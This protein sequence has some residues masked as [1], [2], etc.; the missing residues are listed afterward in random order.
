[1]WRWCAYKGTFTNMTGLVVV[2]V[3][4][5]RGK[6]EILLNKEIQERSKKT[7]IVVEVGIGAGIRIG[8]EE[9]VVEWLNSMAIIVMVKVLARGRCWEEGQ[10]MELFIVVKGRLCMFQV[11]L[12]YPRVFFGRISFPLDQE[13]AGC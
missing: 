1:M 10:R 6:K 4:I 9:G 7:A 2:G 13:H 8:V 12:R 3:R 11:L 5:T